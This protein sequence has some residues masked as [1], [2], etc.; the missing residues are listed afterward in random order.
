MKVLIKLKRTFN[1]RREELAY[2]KK[3]QRIYKGVLRKQKEETMIVHY[4]V[5]GQN[6]SHVAGNKQ[7]NG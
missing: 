3:Y 4:R 1:L 5:K 2:I 7:R 6:K